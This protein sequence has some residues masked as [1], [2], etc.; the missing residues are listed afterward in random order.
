MPN[1]LDSQGNLV[2]T[3][4]DRLISNPDTSPFVGDQKVHQECWS[5]PFPHTAGW[6]T[7]ELSSERRIKATMKLIHM[8]DRTRIARVECSCGGQTSIP[9]GHATDEFPQIGWCPLCAWTLH[10]PTD[11]EK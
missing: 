10:Y 4:C 5:L 2:C 3:V 8:D 7:V 6:D 9:T 1:K 11:L